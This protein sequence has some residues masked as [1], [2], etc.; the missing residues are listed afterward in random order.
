MRRMLKGRCGRRSLAANRTHVAN[1]GSKKVRMGPNGRMI[2]PVNLADV[3]KMTMRPSER[4][5]SET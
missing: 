2:Y 3:E 4:T 1:A 5:V